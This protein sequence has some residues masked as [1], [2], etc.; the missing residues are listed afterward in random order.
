MYRNPALAADA[1]VLR[2]TK[3][4]HLE[5]IVLFVSAFALVLFQEAEVLSLRLKRV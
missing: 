3:D 1:G 4:G 5:V 2:Q